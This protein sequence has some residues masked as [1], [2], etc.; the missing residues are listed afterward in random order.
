MMMTCSSTGVADVARLDYPAPLVANA[1]DQ[2]TFAVDGGW[3]IRWIQA[4]DRDKRDE[5]SNTTPGGPVADG[6]E[7]TIAVPARTGDMIVGMTLWA[8]SGDGRTV[9]QLNPSVWVRVDGP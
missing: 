2:L 9:A 6:P 8:V 3:H 1:G 7:V 5:G 4:Y